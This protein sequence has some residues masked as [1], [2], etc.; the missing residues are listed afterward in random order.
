MV[1]VL[2]NKTPLSELKTLLSVSTLIDIKLLQREKAIS[3]MDVTEEGIVTEDKPL[4]KKALR[5]IYA[6]ELGMVIEVKSLQYA[7]AASPIETTE[8]GI[9]MEIK[10]LKLAKA[11]RL[12]DVIPLSITTAVTELRYANH[13]SKSMSLVAGI[14]PVPL[15]ISVHY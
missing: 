4:S 12:T 14:A 8:L 3:P 2:L 13:G 15:M 9:V 11:S 7:K 10:P 5:P 6:T 1:F